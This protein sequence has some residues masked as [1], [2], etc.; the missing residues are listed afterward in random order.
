MPVSDLPIH[1]LLPKPEPRIHGDGQTSNTLMVTVG[2]MLATLVQGLDMTISNVALPYMAGTF[3]SSYDQAT[4]ILTC[5]IIAAAIMTPPTGWLAA[6]LGR[7]RLFLIAILGFVLASILC[8]LCQTLSEAIFARIL[9]GFMGAAL[10][11]LSQAT[12][13]DTYPPEK[14]PQAMAIL[15]HGHYAWPYSRANPGRLAHVQLELAVGLFY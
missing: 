13:L 2:V 12:L 14:H 4:W 11:P 7:R 3:G 15:G 1:H 10:T 5:Y 9:Q 8:G 6:R